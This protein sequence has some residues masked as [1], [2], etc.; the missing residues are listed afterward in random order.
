[1]IAM[2]VTVG[3]AE[4]AGGASLV[5][6]FG[7]KLARLVDEVKQASAKGEKCVVFSAW[8]RLLHLAGGALADQ[9]IT[10]SSLA[11]SLD[12]RKAALLRFRGDDSSK[13]TAAATM[14]GSESSALAMGAKVLLVPLFG[15]SSGAG[16]GGAAGLTLTEANVAILLEPALQPGCANESILLGF[17]DRCS[18]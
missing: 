14:V 6:E 9:N 1:M 15:G 12:E 11:G 3:G 7:T 16:G 18:I 13:A 17:H 10:F 2:L 8:S 4:E 5:D